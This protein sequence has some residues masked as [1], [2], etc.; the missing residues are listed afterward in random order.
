MD[1]QIGMMEEFGRAGVDLNAPF[2]RDRTMLHLAAGSGNC[3]L[4]EVLLRSNAEMAKEGKPCR[5]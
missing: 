1:R 4:V 2:E 5:F 3:D